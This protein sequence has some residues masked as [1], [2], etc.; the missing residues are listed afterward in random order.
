M[1]SVAWV[2]LLPLLLAVVGVVFIAIAVNDRVDARSDD[3][4]RR[5]P[6]RREHPL[7]HLHMKIR[8]SGKPPSAARAPDAGVAK[9]PK[10][11]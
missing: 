1:S 4:S 2:V 7:Y 8:S 6:T 9:F 5:L 3:K 11:H 10:R